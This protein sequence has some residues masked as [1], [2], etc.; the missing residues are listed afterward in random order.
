MRARERPHVF[1]PVILL[2]DRQGLEHLAAEQV[3]QA[4]LRGIGQPVRE[5]NAEKRHREFIGGKLD[6]AAPADAAGLRGGL[7]HLGPAAHQRDHR[8]ADHQIEGAV[9]ETR[10]VAGVAP[11]PPHRAGIF[12]SSPVSSDG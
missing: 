5:G 12:N 6:P 3:Q 9:V 2:I 11:Q 4:D 7:L 8:V 1:E 10:E